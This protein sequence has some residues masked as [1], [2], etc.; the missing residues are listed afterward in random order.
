MNNKNCIVIAAHINDNGKAK[1]LENCINSLK[2]H[3]PEYPIILACTGDAELAHSQLKLADYYVF[4]SINSLKKIEEPMTVYY[5]TPAWTMCY[6]MQLPRYEYGFAELQKKAIG[7][8]SALSLGFENFLVINYDL[9]LLED[10]FI[11][12]IFSEKKSVFFKF[13]NYD[14]RTSCDV[15]KLDVNGAKAIMQL[16]SNENLVRDLASK[17][18]GNMLED[19]IGE[20]IKYYNIEHRTFRANNLELF[21]L[22]PFKVLINT[23]YNEGAMSAVSKDDGIL[24]LLVTGAGHPR[25]TLDKKLS[26]T[27]GDQTTNYEVPEHM[28]YLHPICKYEGNDVDIKVGT[29]FGDFYVTLRKEVIEN[30]KIIPTSEFNPS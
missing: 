4:T 5:S 13:D 18:S 15:Y 23:S 27:Y 22:S 26:I 16:A 19:V 21:Q 12:Y 17:H 1:T 11:D 7:L 24:Y 20:A 8:Q 30:S 14:V 25:F 28:A 9:L 10:G 3:A 6:H 2:K 29:S